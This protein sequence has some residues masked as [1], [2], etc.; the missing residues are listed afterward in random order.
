MANYF[1]A[2]S[3]LLPVGST[4][5]LREALAIYRTMVEEADA[6]DTPLGFEAEA[7]MIPKGDEPDTVW[8]RSEE[9]GNPEEVLTYVFRCAEALGL[10]G[11]WGFRWGMWCSRPRLDGSGG[12]AHVVD[13]GKRETKCWVDLDQWLTEKTETLQAETTEPMGLHQ[14]LPDASAAA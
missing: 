9:D 14:Q 12:G 1:T 2:F 5:R 3:C 8:I 4:E 11:I 10:S 7:H 13:L 6:T